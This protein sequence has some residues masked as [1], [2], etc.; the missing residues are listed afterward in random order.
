MSVT[1]VSP[2][3]LNETRPKTE[4]EFSE[5]GGGKAKSDVKSE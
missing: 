5:V 2:A 1:C 3:K 4:V